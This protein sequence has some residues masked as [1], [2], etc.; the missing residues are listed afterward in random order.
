MRIGAAHRELSRSRGEIFLASGYSRVSHALRLRYFGSF[1]LP[2]GAHRW[3]KDR[4]GLWWLGKIAHQARPETSS[5]DSCIVRFL[6]DP[7]PIKADLLP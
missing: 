3:Y 5:P 6:D 2:A 4:D 7:G 1:A